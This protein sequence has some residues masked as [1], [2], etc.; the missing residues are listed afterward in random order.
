MDNKRNKENNT[1]YGK[2][3]DRKNHGQM[4]RIYFI[5]MKKN[6]KWRVVTHIRLIQR[7]GCYIVQRDEVFIAFIKLFIRKILVR[8]LL[9]ETRAN[10]F[11]SNGYNKN[12]Q[13]V[14]TFNLRA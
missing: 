11:Q 12:D 10:K 14:E 8:G 3:L 6:F 9:V 1:F 4:R 7:K 5:K 13:I 2:I